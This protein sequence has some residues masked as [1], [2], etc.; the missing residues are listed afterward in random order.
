MLEFLKFT[1]YSGAVI[2]RTVDYSPAFLEIGLAE[3]IAVC[4]PCDPSVEE[5]GGL[6]VFLYEAAQN[7]ELIQD[8]N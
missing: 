7:F 8:Q 3:K 1:Y 6:K 5:V 2:Q 4:T